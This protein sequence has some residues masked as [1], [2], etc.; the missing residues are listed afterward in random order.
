M[1][2]ESQADQ[3]LFGSP[4]QRCGSP[5]NVK[6]VSC[7]VPGAQVAARAAGRDAPMKLDRMAAALIWVAGLANW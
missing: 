3:Y 4:R 6:G 5:V 7:V 2:D 1:A